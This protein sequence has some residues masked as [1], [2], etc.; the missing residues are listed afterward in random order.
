[1]NSTL[2]KPLKSARD[3]KNLIN[4]ENILLIEDKLWTILESFRYLQHQSQGG[5]NRSSLSSQIPVSETLS[6]QTAKKQADIALLCE[7]WWEITHEDNINYLD[8]LF[9]DDL[10]RRSVRQ[11]IILELMSVTVCYA[12]TSER[13]SESDHQ[14]QHLSVTVLTNLKNLLFYTHQNFLV[15]IDVIIHR[16]PPESSHNI[17]AH[18]LQAILLN[19]S[20][21]KLLH[22]TGKSGKQGGG[23]GG[24]ADNAAPLLVQNNEAIM[25]ILRELC[26]SNRESL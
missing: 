11:S 8:R 24:I 15:L 23:N 14:Q 19:K 25:G 18:S 9:K 6:Q 21:R 3:N 22:S 12:V 26:K 16:L 2:E 4:L 13:S 7:E 17:W 20:S 5:S 1:M 10:V